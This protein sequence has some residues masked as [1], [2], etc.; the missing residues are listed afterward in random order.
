MTP[1]LIDCHAHLAQFDADLSDVEHGLDRDGIA[2]LLSA[3]MD[4]K[5]SQEAVD[6]ASRSPKVLGSI[7]LHPWHVEE[8]WAEEAHLKAFTALASDPNC[9]AISEVG[10]DTNAVDVPLS[11]QREA[12]RWFIGLAQRESLPMVL[13]LQVP[14][15]ELLDVWTAI[16]GPMPNAAIHGFAGT[17]RDAELLLDHGFWLSL[18]T[19]TTGRLLGGPPADDEIFL[20]VPD[21]RLLLDSDAYVPDELL[22]TVNT[23]N[24]DLRNWLG[25]AEPLEA[26][27]LLQVADHV[28]AVRGTSV[29]A[30]AEVV[31][32]S[33]DRFLGRPEGA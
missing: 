30:L 4:L 10:L 2:L 1:A 17:R 9:V 8:D 25:D 14:V 12:F 23:L 18:G 26:G 11:L 16:E 6:L 7:G 21:E 31:R 20:S 29:E 24:E 15:E 3:G 22:T 32:S 27:T 19:I 33:F 13:H 28:A 5:S